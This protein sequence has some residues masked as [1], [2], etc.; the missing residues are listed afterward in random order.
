VKDPVAFTL[1][2][3]EFLGNCT[4]VGESQTVISPPGFRQADL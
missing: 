3:I 1:E 4:L 2:L